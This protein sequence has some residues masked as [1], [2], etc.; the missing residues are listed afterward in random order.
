MWKIQLAVANNNDEERV[1][2]S[3]SDNTEIMINDK[4]EEV[5]EKVFESL[6]NR[7]QTNL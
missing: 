4:A 7:Y 5:I 1:I 2:Y 3:K 6:K